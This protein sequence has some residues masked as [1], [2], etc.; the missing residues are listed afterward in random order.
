MKKLA[1]LFCVVVC[2]VAF[3]ACDAEEI[4][5]KTPYKTT[6]YMR[7]PN[8]VLGVPGEY[9]NLMMVVTSHINAHEGT[10]VNADT[11]NTITET[12]A[13]VIPL[14]ITIQSV[15]P[16]EEVIKT[17]LFHKY[18]T[19]A[20]FNP[21]SLLK[22]VDNIEYYYGFELS[23]RS[24]NPNATKVIHSGGNYQYFWVTSNPEEEWADTDII[25]DDTFANTPTYYALAV[26]I[27]GAVGAVVYFACKHK[28]TA[29]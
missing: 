7:V 1:C 22:T 14:R 10:T 17:T 11:A 18:R 19:T 23:Y 21:L 29:I 26:I 25:F 6:V 16:P 12:D 28:K 5:E 4:T 20:L 15:K 24:T 13:A 3:S 9:D 2:M 27:A 8:T